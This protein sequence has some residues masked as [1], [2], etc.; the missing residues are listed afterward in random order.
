MIRISAILLAAGLSQRMGADKLLMEFNGKS[1]LQHSIDL[2]Y[3]LPVSER[4]VV[5]S[6][7][8]HEFVIIPEGVQAI[9]NTKQ[10]KGQ[11]ESIRLGIT[12]LQ[13]MSPSSTHYLFLQA[14][15]PKLMAADILPLLEAAKRNPD[16]IIYPL[17]NKH[18]SSPAIFPKKFHK[19]LL[20]LSGDIGGRIIREENIDDS[21]GIKAEKP[22][23]FSD[24]DI[25]DDILKL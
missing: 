10:E 19:E 15:Q 16:K 2:L 5:L 3:E 17:I 7:E 14:D 1:L 20:S 8:R 24:I 11:S 4:S 22:E 6:K 18:P 25:M 12:A 21:M 13:E 9:L 23:N